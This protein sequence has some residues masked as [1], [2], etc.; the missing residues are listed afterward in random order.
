MKKSYEEPN[1]ELL[2]FVTV[3]VVT[4]SN[5]PFQNPTIDNGEGGWSTIQ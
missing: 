5:D 3:D 4:T 1:M 2:R